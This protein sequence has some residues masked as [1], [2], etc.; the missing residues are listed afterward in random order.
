MLTFPSRKIL[1]NADTVFS[2]EK[3]K[4]STANTIP[5]LNTVSHLFTL[6]HSEADI[7][8]CRSISLVDVGLKR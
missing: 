7:A 5:P 2:P 1:K 6:T 3:I 8:Y 4:T